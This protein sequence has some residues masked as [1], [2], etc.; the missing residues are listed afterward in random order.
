MIR[1]FQMR[2]AFLPAL[3][4]ITIIFVGAT[5]ARNSVWRHSTVLWEDIVRKSPEKVRGH[6][7]LGLIYL[8]D[9]MLDEA[10]GEFQKSLHWRPLDEDLY[11]NIASIYG[12]KGLSDDAIASYKAAIKIKPDYTEAHFNLGLLYLG[13]GLFDDASHEFE[14][15]LRLDPG[16]EQARQFLTYI[17]N[18]R[19]SRE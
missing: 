12:K 2:I 9:D 11:Y 15:S 4:L 1:L 3:V 17:A 10:L 6:S 16:D 5:Y 19:P 7:Q 18:N 13:R 14:I 8:K